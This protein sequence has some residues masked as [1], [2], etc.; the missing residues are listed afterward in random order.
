MV[1]RT[2][3]G[4]YGVRL[5]LAVALTTAV[6]CLGVQ[7]SAYADPAEDA[8]VAD[9]GSHLVSTDPIDD[10]QSTIH[11]YSASMDR[12]IPLRVI[13]PADTS[14]PRPTL[15]LLNGAGGGEDSATWQARTDV[16]DFFADKNV[17]VVTP[18]EGAFSYYTDWEQT[19][20]ELGNN[21]WTTFLTQELPP[22]VDSALGTNGVNSIAG[23]SMAGSSV[24]SLAQSAPDLYQSVGAYS[25][26]AMTSTDPGRAY[27][28][29]VV[30][31]R[32]GGDTSNMWGPEDGPG[33]A[34][35]DPYINAEKLRG[36]DIYVS[37][38][39]G[40]PGAGDQLN[41]PG[42]N[43]DVGTLANQILVGGAIE[44]A[45]NQCTHALADRLNELQ[46]PATFD[47]RPTGTH[48]WTYW[49]EDLHKSWPMLAASIGL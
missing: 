23:I 26:C 1:N 5:A 32:G 17:N 9:G 40:L 2:A 16:V 13:T 37:N 42:I 12:E 39:S 22:I 31:G 35:N 4:R 43:G 15:Y 45:T 24:L 8:T 28:R 27:V 47:F 36:L 6:P 46:I 38:G 48:S 18:M 44:A 21:K 29:M 10:R 3:A 11:V 25:G 34:A 19:D 20:P 41:A 33:W 14:A 49:Q 7:A 30:E